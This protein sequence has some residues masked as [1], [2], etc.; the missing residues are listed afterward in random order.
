MDDEDFTY[1][2]ETLKYFVANN[3]ILSLWAPAFALAVLLRV[4]TSKYHHQLIFPMCTFMFLISTV[5]S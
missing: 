3:H 4:I 1:T 2:F 5:I